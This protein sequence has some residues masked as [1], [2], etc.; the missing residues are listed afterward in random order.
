[1]S[2]PQFR[3]LGNSATT[4]RLQPTREA[5]AVAAAN[6]LKSF[7]PCKSPEDVERA[8]RQA[9]GGFVVSEDVVAVSASA[10]VTP[11]SVSRTTEWRRWRKKEDAD[12]VEPLPPKKPR[13]QY[14]CRKCGGTS[15][16]QFYGRRWCPATTSLSLKDWMTQQK[17]DRDA[18]KAASKDDA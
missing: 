15:H 7:P 16:P 9:A 18:K 2:T 3:Y 13:K 8:A 4:I 10:D 14:T 5:D 17:A 6:K 11:P 12:R 1:M